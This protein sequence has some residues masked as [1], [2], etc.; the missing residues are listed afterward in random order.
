MRTPVKLMILVAVAYAT[1]LSACTKDTGC[2]NVAPADEE[3]TLQAYIAKKGYTAVKHSTGLYYQ[4]LNPGSSNKPTTSSRIYVAYKVQ[5]LQDTLIEQVT[6]P[7][8]TGF[9]L[10]SLVESW[11]IG[12]PLIGKGGSIRLF[13]PSGLAYGCLGSGATIPPNTPLFFEISLTDFL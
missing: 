8:T 11:K 1:V 9:F 6:N 13:S 3:A 10:S 5:T 12:I 7:G 2:K 4:I